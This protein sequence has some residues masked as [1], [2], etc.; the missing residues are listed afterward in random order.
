MN[1]YIYTAKDQNG[2][3]VKAT[4]EA[5]NKTEAAKLLVE[6]NLF[7]IDITPPENASLKIRLQRMLKDV[8]PIKAKDRV[9]LTRQLATLIKAGLPMAK[10]LEILRSQIDNEKLQG[11]VED[12]SNRVEGGS[13]LAEAMGAYPDVFD[14]IYL[15]MVESG[16]LGGN[17]DETLLRLAKQEEKDQE[18][19]SQI[20]SALTYPSVVLVVLIAVTVLMLV[21]VIPEVANMYEEMNEPL[22]FSTRVMQAISNFITS[23]W[24]V[25]LLLLAGAVFAFR[26][27]L[28]TD[29]GKAKFDMVKLNMPVVNLLVKKVYMARFTRT[30]SS[31]IN[32]GVSVLQALHITGKGINN[33]HLEKEIENIAERVKAGD[34]I[35]KPIANSHLFLPLVG[36]MIQVGEETGSMGDSMDRVANYFEA[37]VDEA[38]GNIS[39]LI[40]PITMVVLGLIVAFLIAAVLL[41]IYGLISNIQY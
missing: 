4:V 10:A 37:E 34:P 11:I 25:V 16:E 13:Q 23:Y 12:V 29:A 40:E 31:L 9:I 35:S 22:P 18:I 15:S 36:Q 17:L 38:M 7:P 39:T 19:R 33:V 5:A 3:V 2:K 21:M 20:R 28:H 32:S 8:R 6:Q 27:Y 1:E 26:A 24:Y 41:P 30:M 14:S